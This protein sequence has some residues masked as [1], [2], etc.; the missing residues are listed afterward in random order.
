[1]HDTLYKKCKFLAF[2]LQ[3]G[4]RTAFI[5]DTTRASFRLGAVDN[6]NRMRKS[7][8]PEEI[9]KITAKNMVFDLGTSCFSVNYNF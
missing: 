9:A 6:G 1:L 5:D 4:R 8:N 3:T 7:C 2:S